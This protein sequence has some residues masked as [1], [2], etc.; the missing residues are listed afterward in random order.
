MPDAG[1]RILDMGAGRVLQGRKFVQTRRAGV[2]P[3]Q[4]EMSAARTSPLTRESPA[5]TRGERMFPR[6]RSILT[7]PGSRREQARALQH[8]SV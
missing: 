6:R 3:L 4:G 5:A 2:I 8:R 1:C 7:Y